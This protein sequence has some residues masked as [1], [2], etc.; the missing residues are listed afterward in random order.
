[1]FIFIVRLSD[2]IR[3]VLDEELVEAIVD[4]FGSP[5]SPFNAERLELLEVDGVIPNR[6]GSTPGKFPN[7]LLLN[8]PLFIFKLPA[9]PIFMAIFGRPGALLRGRP[10]GRLAPGIFAPG[11]LAEKLPVG[12]FVGRPVDGS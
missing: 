6:R 12:R 9:M 8:I 7:G 2:G 10:P 1:M 5:R 3:L 11:R 4:R